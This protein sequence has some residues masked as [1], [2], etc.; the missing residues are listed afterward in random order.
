[1]K[2]ILFLIDSLTGGGAEKV[3]VNLVNNMDTT[4][5]DITVETMFFDGVNAQFLKP[6][7]NY[8][9]RKAP[10][11]H[12]ISHV[13]KRIPDTLLYKYFVGNAKYD[14]QVGS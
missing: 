11:F 10:H 13:L 7:I 5:Y 3:L 9:C 4:E 2:K 8:F 1:M 14:I 6:E 12:G